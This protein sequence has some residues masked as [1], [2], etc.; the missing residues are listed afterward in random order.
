MIQERLDRKRVVWSSA[1][2]ELDPPT[3]SG[4]TR[5]CCAWSPDGL[6][7]AISRPG[8][9][10][11]VEVV[12][13]DSKKRLH[14][15]DHASSPAWSPDGTKCAFIRPDN[16][17]NS[18]EYI[19]RH[20]QTFGD[21]RQVAAAGSIASAPFW[22]SDSRS[23]LAV[24]EKSAIRS[25]ELDI[26]RFIL[27][28]AESMRLMS[29]VPDPM[30]RAAKVRGLVVDFDRDAERCF[31]AVDVAG[32]DADIVWSVPRER[33]THKR[34]HPLDISLR[35]EALAVSPDG[36]QVAVRLELA[37]RSRSAGDL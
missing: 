10:P 24:V 30:R 37:A 7:L 33:V 11:A 21:A 34:F 13:A 32:R 6:Y 28:P 20:G 25:N 5:L 8:R 23:I 27:E 14:L 22:S 19:E 16:G 1:D 29:L 2:I 3:R 31:F 12:R 9:Q 17:G 15:L 18:L 35:I 26:V 4:L 36:L